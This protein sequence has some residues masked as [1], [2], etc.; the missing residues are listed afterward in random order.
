VEKPPIFRHDTTGFELKASHAQVSCRGCHHSLVF[1]QVGTACADCHQDAHRGELGFRCAWCHTPTTWTNQRDM[2]QVHSRT[3]FPLLAVH[4]RLDCAACHGSQEPWQ[5]ATTPAECGSCHLETYLQ[6]SDPNH[7]EAGFSRRC[8]DCHQ[9]TASS[10]R[11]A[12]SAHPQ[13]F[14]LVGG[15][16][17]LACDRCHAGGTYT[18]LSRACVSCH[19]ADYLATANPNHT[20]SGFSTTCEGCHTVDAWRPANFDHDSRYFPIYSGAHRGRWSDCSDCHVMPGNY[21]AFECINCHAHSRSAMDREHEGEVRG[22][23]YD[24]AA[25]YR[26]HRRGVGDDSFSGPRRLPR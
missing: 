9:V 25:C 1:H 4:A 24:S 19:Q 26:C 20:A 6:T 18:G 17:R 5:Y 15:H 2:F 23:T 14:P 11:G 7:V 10:W 16:A 13:S 22:Y 12:R 3:R 8:E 21:A